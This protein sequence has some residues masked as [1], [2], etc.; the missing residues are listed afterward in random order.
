[1]S[2]IVTGTIVTSIDEGTSFCLFWYG[3]TVQFHSF[4][5]VLP[6]IARSPHGSVQK[7]REEW[8]CRDSDF[9]DS[10]SVKW[11]SNTKWSFALLIVWPAWNRCSF[12]ALNTTSGWSPS[13]DWC[14]SPSRTRLCELHSILTDMFTA[15]VEQSQLSRSGSPT[16]V[17]RRSSRSVALRESESTVGV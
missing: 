14:F 6:V 11:F 9:V 12:T 16:V 3:L 17:R 15:V 2:N 8:L 7:I 4:V 5:T 10:S 1:M 13:I